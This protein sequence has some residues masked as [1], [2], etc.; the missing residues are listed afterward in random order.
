MSKRHNVSDAAS[1][2]EEDEMFHE[3]EQTHESRENTPLQ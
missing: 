1:E 2:D 3:A